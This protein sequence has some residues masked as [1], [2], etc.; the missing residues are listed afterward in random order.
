M[1]KLLFIPLLILSIAL[2]A[3]RPLSGLLLG[4]DTLKKFP[5]SSIRLHA[6]AWDGN[7]SSEYTYSWKTIP[8]IKDRQ[9]QDIEIGTSDT[10][11]LP[12]SISPSLF[13]VICTV[14]DANNDSVQLEQVIK[15]DPKATV[16][17]EEKPRPHTFTGYDYAFDFGNTSYLVTDDPDYTINV[18]GSGASY[19]REEVVNGDIVHIFNSDAAGEY[20]LNFDLLYQQEIIHT[21]SRTMIVGDAQKGAVFA[22]KGHGTIR[23]NGLREHIALDIRFLDDNVSGT[24]DFYTDEPNSQPDGREEFTVVDHKMV[25]TD[26]PDTYFHS[27]DSTEYTITADIHMD[28]GEQ[29]EISKHMTFT[30]PA[31]VYTPNI[32]ACKGDTVIIP[33]TYRNI[34]PEMEIQF[35]DLIV[36]VQ[37]GLNPIS[38]YNSDSKNHYWQTQVETLES[39]IEGKRVFTLIHPHYSY[40]NPELS[41]SIWKLNPYQNNDTIIFIKAVVEKDGVYELRAETASYG[42]F[43]NMPH[44][45]HTG[46]L[47]ALKSEGENT[48][49]NTAHIKGLQNIVKLESQPFSSDFSYTWKHNNTKE[50]GSDTYV[51]ARTEDQQVTLEIED[52]NGC[53]AT[54]K[55]SVLK[56]TDNLYSIAGILRDENNTPLSGEIIAYQLIDGN[57]YPSGKDETTDGT[58]LIENLAAGDYILMGVPDNSDY[59]AAYYYQEGLRT[60]ANQI[61]VTSDITDVDLVLTEKEPTNGKLLEGVFTQ[62]STTNAQ[63]T[64]FESFHGS[65]PQIV[66]LTNDNDE[67]INTATLGTDGSYS[68][69]SDVNYTHFTASHGLVT[70]LLKDDFVVLS[71]GNDLLLNMDVFPNP[72]SSQLKVKLPEEALITIYDVKGILVKEMEGSKGL[73]LLQTAS[74]KPG[75]YI[76]S[77]TGQE[78]TVKMGLTKQ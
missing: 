47:T 23:S 51:D 67:I 48:T 31:E 73:N 29:F 41:Y 75:F 14:K 64:V 3:Q 55:Q 13:K 40:Q 35:F 57:Y 37:Q 34:T 43:I 38:I 1:K 52:L 21:Y 8:Q 4:G 24:V 9:G 76:I 30:G 28:S 53:K 39:N 11:I 19:V 60:N 71:T 10:R 33:I 77:I 78:S 74:L 25:L 6:L 45:E 16:I 36:T 59:N 50:H 27:Y 56:E 44:N 32:S 22:N 63:E 26:N 62:D 12:V 17:T 5:N 42:H 7:T 54:F 2:Q 65:L 72:F 49:I 58:Y 20:T 61:A 46:T 18:S 15:A 69:A 66:F 70:E 68:I